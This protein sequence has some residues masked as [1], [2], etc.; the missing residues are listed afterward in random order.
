MKKKL[1][2][3]FLMLALIFS[4]AGCGSIDEIVPQNSG[5]TQSESNINTDKPVSDENSETL[6]NLEIHFLDV[7]QGDCTLIKCGDDAMLID[8]GNNNKGTLVKSYLNS[9]NIKTLNYVIGTHPDADHIGGLDVVLYNFDCETIIMPNE[10]KDTAT[11]RDVIDTIKHKN[12]QI[13]RP[14]VG[15]T[16]TLGDATFKIISP[17]KDYK[18]CNDSSVSFIMTHGNKTY[19]FTGDC[20]EEAE[21]D[22]LSSNLLSDVDVFKA[23]HHGSRTASTKDFLEK[24]TPEYVVISCGEGNSYGHPHSEV[25]NNLRAMGCDVFRT[26]EQGSILLKSDGNKITWSLSPSTSWQAGE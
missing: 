19:L 3:L 17:A 10:E 16:Y 23:G 25:L 4:I 8:A 13:T 11:Y 9:Q 5:N 21:N 2:N 24:I 20:E 14:T 12:Y 15:A 26:D 7:G 6:D 22:M 1:T 18:D